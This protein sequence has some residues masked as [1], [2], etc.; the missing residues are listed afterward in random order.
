MREAKVMPP[1]AATCAL[2][3]SAGTRAMIDYRK[4]SIAAFALAF[5]GFCMPFV[6]IWQVGELLPPPGM[7]DEN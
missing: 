6:R 7:A 2:A 4:R 3:A 1:G 5:I